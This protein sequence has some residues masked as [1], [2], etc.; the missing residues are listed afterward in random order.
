MTL[1]KLKLN[2]QDHHICV[3]QDAR[4]LIVRMNT[5]DALT[6]STPAGNQ[7]GD[8]PDLRDLYGACSSR[9]DCECLRPG[10]R[11]KGRECPRWTPLGPKTQIEL[12]GFQ[13]EAIRRRRERGLK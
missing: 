10:N 5:F 1:A 11:W 12:A 13:L 4:G 6:D 7:V 2:E 9:G 3:T 8:T